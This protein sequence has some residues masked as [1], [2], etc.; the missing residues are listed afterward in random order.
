MQTVKLVI[1]I[2]ICL[3]VLGA[4][5]LKGPLYLPSE[6]PVAETATGQESDPT[7][8][9]TEK[10]QDATKKDSGINNK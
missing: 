10:K 1:L 4:C 7:T 2:L 3:I 6:S 5:G 9:E 8:D